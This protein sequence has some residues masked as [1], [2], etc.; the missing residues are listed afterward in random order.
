MT[1]DQTNT[2]AIMSDDEATPHFDSPEQEI[3]HWKSKVA[4][5]QDALREAQSTLNE[6]M[7]SSK[8]LEAEMEREITASNKTIGDLQRNNDILKS[9]VE[10][11][12]LKYQQA[13]AEHNSMMN[14]VTREVNALREQHN[15]YKAKLRDMEMDNDELENAERMIASSLADMESRYNKT[16][17]RT[18]LLEEELVQKSALQDENQRLKDELRDLSEE[19]AILR[20]FSSRSRATSRTDTIPEDANGK[21]GAD[22]AGAADAGPSV[23]RRERP[24]S[25]N[26]DRPSSRQALASPSVGRT[27]FSQRVAGIHAHARRGSRDI[28]DHMV[29]PS[30]SESPDSMVRSKSARIV[31][32]AGRDPTAMGSPI[33]RSSLRDTIRG[34]P[35]TPTSSS[36][37]P[38]NANAANSM[39]MMHTMVAK[40]KTLEGRI[41]SARNLSSLTAVESSIPRPSSRV[42][43]VGAGGYASP[44]LTQSSRRIAQRPSLDGK[45]NIASSIPLPTSG[46]SRS[47]T[48]RPS[49]RLSDNGTPPMPNVGLPRSTTP[50]SQ[51]STPYANSSRGPSPLEFMDYDP[52]LTLSQNARL[53]STGLPR[54]R[55][56]ITS[57]A[58]TAAKVRGGSALPVLGTA[59]VRR[60]AGGRATSTNQRPPSGQL[61]KEV[62]PP[63]AWKATARRSRSGS[64][65]VK[66]TATREV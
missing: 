15:L 2:D 18:A 42:G 1:L 22:E 28:R 59:A 65:V 20:D 11:W 66:T 39:M 37:R 53:G 24:V 58:G 48:R 29:A 38:R 36:S 61:V 5:M 4:D 60:E 23:R 56:S 40:M 44:S 9:S 12:K 17:E 21:H 47:T 33:G 57:A 50:S 41:S 19:V 43:S 49:S 31:A 16:I 54:R 10:D 13:L 3:K 7:E 45:S 26:A 52:A 32:S 55:S 35:R 34:V 46:L 63:T 27:N 64:L 8:D 6:F 62:G 14:N 51:L 25:Y 30:H